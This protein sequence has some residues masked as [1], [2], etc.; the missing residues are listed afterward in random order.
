MLFLVINLSK[1]VIVMLVNYRG[2]SVIIKMDAGETG[3]ITL[4]DGYSF[5]SI[6]VTYNEN[7]SVLVPEVTFSMGTTLR[8]PPVN[9]KSPCV[10]Q[11]LLQNPNKGGTLRFLITKF[12]QIPDPHYF[13]L[14]KYFDPILVKDDDGKEYNVIPSDQFK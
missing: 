9:S 11:P 1:A 10:I 7:I 3:S 14:N 5:E 4:P 12:G 13:D 2:N 8:F 6:V